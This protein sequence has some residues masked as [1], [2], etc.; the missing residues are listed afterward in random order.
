MFYSYI[1]DKQTLL[2]VPSYNSKARPHDPLQDV[3]KNND[4]KKGCIVNTKEFY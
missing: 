1:K 2:N 4:E 3:K